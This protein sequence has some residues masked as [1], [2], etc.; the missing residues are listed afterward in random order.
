[1]MCCGASGS[2]DTGVVLPAAVLGH[3]VVVEVPDGGELLERPR[4]TGAVAVEPG[5]RGVRDGVVLGEGH[6]RV[7]VEVEAHG[8]REHDDRVVCGDEEPLGP[9]EPVD[10][11]HHRAEPEHDVRPRLPARGPVVVLAEPLSAALLVRVAVAHA[12]SGEQVEDT[13]LPVAQ[14]FVGTPRR[15]GQAAGLEC[16]ADRLLRASVGRHPQRDRDVVDT[17]VGE[18]LPERPRLLLT[19]GAERD[20]GIAVVDLDDVRARGVRT[21]GGDV[22]GGLPVADEPDLGDCHGRDANPR[23]LGPLP[24][25]Q[26]VG[27]S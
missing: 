15:L 25:R 4:R 12:L 13:E 6:E 27:R 16:D 5:E 18:L 26:P 1:M 19:E 7:L 17:T 10:V 11:G 9:L 20:V 14:P 24:V 23:P 8:H 3:F 22:G 2:L 21:G